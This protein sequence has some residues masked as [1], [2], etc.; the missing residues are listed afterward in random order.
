[1]NSTNT[2][3]QLLNVEHAIRLVQSLPAHKINLAWFTVRGT[4]SL[5]LKDYLL[6]LANILGLLWA[7]SSRAVLDPTSNVAACLGGLVAADPFFH[8]QGVRRSWIWGMPIKAGFSTY[9][10]NERDL[11]LH[12]FGLTGL[13]LWDEHLCMENTERQ[14]RYLVHALS[15]HRDCLIARLT[16]KEARQWG[17]HVAATRAGIKV[18]EQETP[19]TN[20]A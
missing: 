5:G 10:A 3:R 12:L 2:I 8:A 14:H 6:G 11:S 19:F 16:H 18:Q 17:A 9:A 1:M 7:P 15:Q 20:A 13:F 4:G